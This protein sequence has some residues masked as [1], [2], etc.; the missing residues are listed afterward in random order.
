[1]KPIPRVFSLKSPVYLA[2]RSSKKQ[3]ETIMSILNWNDTSVSLS[4]AT[5]YVKPAIYVADF[6]TS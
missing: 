4:L 3:V 1:M 2:R 6:M 5:G